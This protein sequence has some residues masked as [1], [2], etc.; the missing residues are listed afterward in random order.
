[1]D[2]DGAQ[3]SLGV[4]LFTLLGGFL[5]AVVLYV[6]SIGPV[7]MIVGKGRPPKPI[8]MFYKPLEWTAEHTLLGPPI[9]GYV[10]W[11]VNLREGRR[12]P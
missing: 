10:R 12:Q 4:R 9:L 5:L 1:M 3:R 6:A 11:W 7:I 2:P 8:E